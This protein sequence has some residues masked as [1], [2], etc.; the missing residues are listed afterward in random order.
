M[1]AKLNLLKGLKEEKETAFE[2]SKDEKESR[3]TKSNRDVWGI[4]D[5]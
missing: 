3:Q 1:P 4:K 2:E 5:S